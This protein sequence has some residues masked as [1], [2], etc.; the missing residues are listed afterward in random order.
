L[1]VGGGVIEGQ[2]GGGGIAQYEACQAVTTYLHTVPYPLPAN[3]T[4]FKWFLSVP[5]K[6]RLQDEI[7]SGAMMKKQTKNG[8][9]AKRQLSTRG[10]TYTLLF[11]FNTVKRRTEKMYTRRIRNTQ[12]C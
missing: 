8:L 7:D 10:N 3:E 4:T 2:N 9:L 6:I 11:H 5:P 1:L 12:H